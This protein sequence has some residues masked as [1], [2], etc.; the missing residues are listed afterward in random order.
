MAPLSLSLYG[1]LTWLLSPVADQILAAR[2]RA[3]KEDPARLG[4]RRG[5]AGHPRPPGKLAWL[6][7]VSVGE[8]VSLL[9]LIEAL[10]RDRPDLNLLVTSGTRTSADLLAERLP[11]GV[12]HQYVPVDTPAAVRRFMA[13]WQPDLGVLVESELWPNLI[14]A[15]RRRAMPLALISARIT[16]R[17]ARGWQRFPHLARHLLSSLALV[18]PQDEA[19]AN[20]LRGLGAR[21]GPQLNLK[22]IAAPPPDAPNERERL[23]AI[24]GDRPVVLAASTHPG[25]EDLILAALPP[26]PLLILAPRHPVRGPDLAGSLRQK[27]HSLAQRSAGEPLSATTDVYLAD[28]LGEMG[29][30]FAL[31]DITVMGGGFGPGIGGHNPLEPAWF[32]TAILTGPHAFNSAAVYG[33]MFAEMAALETTDLARDL[34]GLLD[35]PMVARRMGEAALTYVQRQGA[36]LDQTLNLLSP[37]L[38]A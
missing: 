26:R 32:G 33:E 29:L 20:R 23:A 9:P 27:G 6:H 8:S 11:Q 24:I 36:A 31:A 3:G 4:E 18:C 7:A 15:A 13:H 21:V 35:Y 34:K 37:L 12:I 28:T 16:E 1:G 10:C 14:E 5:R 22:R 19:S 2:A 38:P 17:S 30:F 25:D